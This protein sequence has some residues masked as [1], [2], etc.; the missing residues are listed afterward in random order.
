MYTRGG[1]FIRS[2]FLRFFT[3]DGTAG[4]AGGQEVQNQEPAFPANTPVKDMTPEQQV[5]YWQDKARK[6]ENRNK[7][8]GDWTPEKIKALQ[9]ERDALRSQGQTDTEKEL[10]KA[11]E[12][13]RTEV[14]S[15]L[16]RER[17]TS[18]LEKALQGRAPDAGALLSLDVN[19]FIVDGKVDDAAVKA[20]VDDHSEEAPKGNQQQR[21]NPDN[22]QGNRG[23]AGGSGKSVAAGRDLFAD[24][25]KKSTTTS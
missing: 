1:I 19:T 10:E 5:G 21:R 17:A 8:L 22:G 12:E 7:A 18:A 24:R 3:D 2:P 25:R 11:R 16:N 6:H 23:N 13:G 15:V 4:G 14:R 20:W 9:D